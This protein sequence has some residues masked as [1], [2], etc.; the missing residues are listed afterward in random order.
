MNHFTR[1]LDEI[2][3]SLETALEEAETDEA[4]YQIRS[5]LQHLEVLSAADFETVES[6]LRP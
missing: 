4:R 3:R 5:S 6:E 2:E 1:S